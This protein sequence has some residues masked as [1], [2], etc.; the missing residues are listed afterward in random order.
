M[1][2]RLRHLIAAIPGAVAPGA[3]AMSAALVTGE[4]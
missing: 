3:V 1:R 2:R 4:N